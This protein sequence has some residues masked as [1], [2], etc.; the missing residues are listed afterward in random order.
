M[1]TLWKIMKISIFLN[2]SKTNISTFL[3]FSFSPDICGGKLLFLETYSGMYFISWIAV[4]CSIFTA[5]FEGI[6]T[7]FSENMRLV[8][9]WGIQFFLIER[10]IKKA[11]EREMRKIATV[12]KGRKLFFEELFWNLY[13]HNINLKNSNCKLTILWSHGFLMFSVDFCRT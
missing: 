11:K 6:S 8:I 5:F 13:L 9:P 10:K 1:K 12:Q 4:W 2:T 3:H 7:A